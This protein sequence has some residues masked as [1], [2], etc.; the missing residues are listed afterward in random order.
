M[1]VVILN[2]DG[3]EPWVTE[4]DTDDQADAFVEAWASRGWSRDESA[5]SDAAQPAPAAPAVSDV[6]AAPPVDPA[7]AE[8]T[9][10]APEGV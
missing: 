2:H 6:P 4:H 7:P 9:T 5:Q 8:P 3:C 10:T 1:P